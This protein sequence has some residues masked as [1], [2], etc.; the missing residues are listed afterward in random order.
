MTS[1]RAIMFALSTLTLAAATRDHSALPLTP[2]RNSGALDRARRATLILR[3]VLVALA[4]LAV[5][6]TRDAR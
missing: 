5:A 4:T 3:A 6:P 1:G 2:S